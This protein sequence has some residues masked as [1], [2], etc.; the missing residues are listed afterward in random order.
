MK[1]KKYMEVTIIMTEEEAMWLKAIMQNEL[2]DDE[3]EHDAAMRRA[4]WE[5]LK[6]EGVR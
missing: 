2:H 5:V 4:F 3:S 6:K 1:A